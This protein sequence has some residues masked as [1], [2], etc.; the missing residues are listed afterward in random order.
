[1]EK[2]TTNTESQ[3]MSSRDL[4][5]TT[6][7]DRRFRRLIG[8]EE[9]ENRL[10]LT[11][12]CIVQHDV[13]DGFGSP[14]AADVDSDGDLDVLTSGNSGLAWYENI[15][16]RGTFGEG[17][18]LLDKN[19]GRSEVG[20]FDGDDDVD[21]VAGSNLYENIHG[22]GKFQA[23]RVGISGGAYALDVS[24]LDGDG[25]AD[26][27][28][29]YGDFRGGSIVWY[30]NA[31]GKGAFSSHS[32]GP[33]SG[34]SMSVVTSDIDGDGDLDV[35]SASQVRYATFWYENV[36]GQGTFGAEKRISEQGAGS[37]FAADID[38]DADIDVLA[39]ISDVAEG[40]GEIVWYENMDGKG[41]FG[42][43][44]RITPLRVAYSVA[45]ADLD[46]DG[47]LDV[48]AGS[49]SGRPGNPGLA[50]H[51]NDGRGSF[52]QHSIVADAAGGVSV[53]DM[54]GDG[55]TDI[56]ARVT[57][58]DGWRIQ[59]FE[60]FMPHPADVN[61]NAQFDELDIAEMLSSGKYLM[62]DPATCAE[63]DWNSDGVFDQHDFLALL[64][65]PKWYDS[66]R[67]VAGDAN[68]DD[69]FD[70][71]D[72]VQV[73]Q[74][75]KY[76]TNQPATWQQG[77]WNGDGVFDQIDIVSAL[78]TNEFGSQ[79]VTVDED[80]SFVLFGSEFFAD[81][82]L[83]GAP[84]FSATLVDGSPL[85]AWLAF[86]TVSGRFQGT[87]QNE[88]VDAIAVKLVA[89][90]TVSESVST[91]F[92]LVVRNLNDTPA[93]VDDSGFS[94]IKVAPLRI[95]ASE[96][97]AND[98]D[99][100]PGDS[101]TITDVDGTSAMGA[102]VTLTAD[103]VVYDPNNSEQISALPRDVQVTDSFRY[104]VQ[105][106][107]GATSTARVSVVVS[108]EE[109]VVRFRLE[110]TDLSGQPIETLTTGQPFLLRAYVQDVRMDPS[111]VFSAHLD[112]AYDSSLT[113]VDGD[114]EYGPTFAFP[115][116][117]PRV[118]AG[119]AIIDEVGAI[120]GFEPT[121]GAEF[122]LLSL[123]FVANSAP[124]IAE[125]VGNS[126]DDE[127][128]HPVVFYDSP[129]PVSPSLTD[130]G[131]IAIEIVERSDG[132]QHGPAPAGDFGF[133]TNRYSPLTILTSELLANDTAANPGEVLA[134]SS[135]E[136]TSTLGAS[137]GLNG[138]SVFYDP[139][140][141]E[142]LAALS[143]NLKVTD[144]FEYTV[145]N[146]EGA[147]ATA[148]VFVTVLGSEASVWFRLESTDLNGNRIETVTT[149]E[150]FLLRGYVQ[151]VRE[152]PSGVF[153]AYLDITY[154]SLLVTPNGDIGYG[155]TFGFPDTTP[156][157]FS[158]PNTIEEV[159]AIAGFNPTGGDEFLLFSLH[160]VAGSVP[161]AT[162][163]VSDPADDSELHPVMAFDLLEAVPTSL[164]H[165]GST[166]IEIVD[167]PSR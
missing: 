120:G 11:P 112:V 167:K 2:F 136:P 94:T 41:N 8:W 140:A 47:D 6:P 139:T 9:L 145:R 69:V 40:A 26:V 93:L 33:L 34:R 149:D 146:S 109:A 166:V 80:S 45:A 42:T 77:D 76:A 121:G 10:C 91:T 16:G 116:T 153:S 21:I 56:L 131:M 32:V 129:G 106:S 82:N 89:T 48:I 97:L 88:D 25:D 29:T 127:L 113:A 44:N 68:L 124:G 126:A 130:Y 39:S 75:D 102:T 12:I 143:P 107:A 114:I 78:Q 159:G 123:P 92:V 108:G 142:Q 90:D 30:E 122:L 165:Y 95:S 151:D 71:R 28:A 125:F 23:R 72:I 65:D 52:T 84:T 115:S 22:N 18:V 51:E 55:R 144:T 53:H 135:V 66:L 160:L 74:A 99:P 54:N 4:F 15:D 46:D 103:S 164:V 5:R 59:W 38:G 161:G 7:R 110:A 27:M 70:Y 64:S 137:V 17:Q 118:P 49:G 73:L 13:T 162:E 14:L 105:D 117:G 85:P 63:G 31:D 3:T 58:D 132:G 61:R 134:I 156:G 19:A 20:D 81:T 147:V 148:E 35:L 138:N 50:W 128:L 163:F 67:R 98:A 100:D 1:M 104:T 158:Q 141:S 37:V 24:D 101:L 79:V 157:R 119:P 96:L 43:A 86:S 83:G 60:N 62:G 36:D 155:P 57:G 87:P 111:G 150:S 154:D 133:R 152:T